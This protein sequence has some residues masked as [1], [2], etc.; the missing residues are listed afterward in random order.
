MYYIYVHV[1]GNGNDNH[2]IPIVTQGEPTNAIWIED[3]YW[4]CR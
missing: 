4:S 1:D 3:S 2:V